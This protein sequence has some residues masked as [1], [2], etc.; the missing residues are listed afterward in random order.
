MARPVPARPGTGRSAR[1]VRVNRAGTVAI[2]LLA[3][4]GLAAAGTPGGA[5]EDST[6]AAPAAVDAASRSPTASPGASPT[7]TPTVDPLAAPTQPEPTADPLV[8]AGA[9]ARRI[10]DTSDG[11][12][13]FT[14]VDRRAGRTVGDSRAAQ[15]TN[16][17][18]VVK[19]WLAA[20]LLASAAAQRRRLTADERS[21]LAA[22]IRVSDDDA[23]EV[24]WRSLG[25]DASI[26]RMIGTCRL[27]DTTVFPGRWSLTRISS[28]DLARLG[29]CLV[30]GAG[31][32]LSARTGGELLALMRSV[33]PSDAFGIQ[34]AQ[35]AGSGVKL[36]VKNGWTEHGGTGRWNVNCLAM[37][38]QSLRW[39]LAVTTRYPIARGLAYGADVC[40]RVT[41]TL[42]P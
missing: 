32:P 34:A 22:M 30:P 42:F 13:S 16:S 5:G 20:D 37:W 41:E 27:T 39:V 18:S 35:P 4:A 17:E 21:R 40:R 24:I 6:A 25:G 29:S 31:R 28:R 15:P 8:E 7:G 23:A 2:V 19:A 12:A 1:S 10:T 26:R 33:A 36:A 9:R 3:I 11:W 14:L 38:G